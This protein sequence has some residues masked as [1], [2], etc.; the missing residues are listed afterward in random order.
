MTGRNDAMKNLPLVICYTNWAMAPWLERF[1]TADPARQILTL[2][3]PDQPLPPRFLLTCWRPAPD[4]FRRIPKP[5]LILCPGAGVDSILSASPPV[6]V[7]ITRIV[8][9]DLTGRMVEYVVLHALYHLRQ[10]D[11]YARSQRERRWAPQHQPAAREVTVGL[12]GIG[13]MG[14][15]AAAGLRAVGFNVIGWSRSAKADAPLPVHHGRDGLADFLSATDILVN[16]LPSTPETRG[17]IDARLIAQLRRPGPL[18]GPALINAGR[19]DAV[20]DADVAEALAS[21]SLRAASLDVFTAEPLP[22]DSPYW[23]LPNVLVT[24]HVAADSMPDAVVT[25]IMAEISRFEAGL[26]PLY[27]VDRRRGY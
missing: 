17:L 8:D 20:N 19:G 25:A 6:D 11:R 2:D 4:L 7:T 3:H 24:P 27:P 21:G 15:A 13:E 22:A 23:G 18:G 5:E 12:M 1:R 16:L 10:M 14:L 9:P 26:P